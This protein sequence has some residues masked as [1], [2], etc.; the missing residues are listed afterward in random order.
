MKSEEFRIEAFD[1]IHLYVKC[2]KPEITSKGVIILIHGLGEHINRYHH[3][4]G[5]FTGDGWTVVGLDLRGH[6]LSEGKRGCGGYEAHLKDIDTI[7]RFVEKQFG[8]TDIILYGHSMGGNF[9]LGY[10]LS[11]KPDISGVVITSPWLRLSAPPAKATVFVVKILSRIIPYFAISNRLASRNLSRDEAVGKEYEKDPR[12]H[13]KISLKLFLDVHQW[14]KKILNS[15]HKLNVPLLLL[16]GSDDRIT[17]WKGS[18]LFALETSQITSFR[19]WDQCYHE[20][21]NELCREDVFKYICSWI[22][23]VP[24]YNLQENAG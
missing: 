12:V 7:V 23:H 2:W 11:R 22:N 15:K 1:K 5:Q 4:A 3:W 13:S 24:T 14:A 9:A 19:I 17:S 8:K 10:M 20:L 16:H 6:G 21:H 18:Y